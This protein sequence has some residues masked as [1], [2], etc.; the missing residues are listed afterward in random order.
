MTMDGIWFST[1]TRNA[2]M[3]LDIALTPLYPY[4][5]KDVFKEQ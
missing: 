2:A 1:N 5:V 3:A 4:N